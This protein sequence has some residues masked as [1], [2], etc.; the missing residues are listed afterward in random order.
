MKRFSARQLH[1]HLQITREPPVLVDVREP[2]EYEIVR[3]PGSVHIPL[4]QI[5]ERLD[6]L[7]PEREIVMICHH[8]VRS[9][10]AAQFLENQG[11]GKLINLEGGIDAWARAI[12]TTLATY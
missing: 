6:E 8:G 7:D 3:I 2:W 10:H 11:Y 9:R 12:D 1:E 5:Q 4:A